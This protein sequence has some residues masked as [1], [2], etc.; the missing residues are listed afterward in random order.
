VLARNEQQPLPFGDQCGTKLNGFPVSGVV[1][2]PEQCFH[3]GARFSV[4]AALS[5]Q[6]V[7]RDFASGAGSTAIGFREHARARRGMAKRVVDVHYQGRFFF[8]FATAQF[9]SGSNVIVSLSMSRIMY[10]LRPIVS[11]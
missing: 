4:T 2:G 3:A 11:T 1:F 5:L 6:E 7:M 10:S 9:T 8:F